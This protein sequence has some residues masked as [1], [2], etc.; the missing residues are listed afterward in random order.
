MKGPGDSLFTAIRDALGDIQVIAEDLGVIT[1]EV[2]AIRDRFGFPGM[3]ILQRAFSNS[4]K[5]AEYRPHNHIYNSAVYTGTH[6]HDTIV[7]WFTADP[8]THPSMTRMD[9][10]MER[11]RVLRY[12]GTEGKEIHWDFIRMAL[13]SVARMAIF[14]LQD[15]L[16]LGREARMNLPG[17]LYGNWEWRFAADMITPAMVHTLA[18]LTEIYERAPVRRT[19]S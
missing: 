6:D 11:R 9:V 10:E 8:G 14:P 5:A 18:T 12:I 16:G 15:V 3:R 2:D 7:G 1:P 19:S 4:S 13:A 17:T